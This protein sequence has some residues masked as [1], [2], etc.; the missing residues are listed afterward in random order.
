[1]DVNIHV[2]SNGQIWTNPIEYK[3]LNRCFIPVRETISPVVQLGQALEWYEGFAGRQ[4]IQLAESRRVPTAPGLG[5]QEGG[6]EPNAQPR[7]H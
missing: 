5:V 7:S 2:H 1:M 6:A 3:A 4:H